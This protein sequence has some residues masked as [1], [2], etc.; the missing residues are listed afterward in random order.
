AAKICSVW[1]SQMTNT[2]VED[3]DKGDEEVTDAAKADAEKTSK[4]KD[5]AK[6][7][8]LPPTSSSL[9]VS[10][11]FGDQFLKLSSDSSLVSTVKDT[12]DAEINSLLEVKIQ[13]EVPHI[14]SPSILIVLV[15]V[16][17]K[18]LVLS[19]VQESPSKATVTTL[20][21]P[22]VSTTPLVPQQTTTSIPIPPIT[23][24]APTITTIQIPELP[25]KQSP[26]VDLEQESEKTPSDILKIKKEQAEKKKMLK[27]TIKS[28]DKA[29]LKE[30]DQKSAIYQTMHAD[31]SFNRNP[32]NHRL[33][34]A[35]ME[36]LIED[37]H[38]IDKGVAYTVQDHK[39]KHDDDEDDDDEDP[40]AGPNQCK[41]IKRRRIKESNSSKKPS[42]TKETPKGKAPSKGFKIGKSASAKEPVKEP[43][44]EVVMDDAGEDVVRNDDQPQD[45][46]EPK[47]TKTPNLD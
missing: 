33:Y 29:A 37:E 24:D 19:T 15:S 23:T 21:P 22:S 12:T 39:R 14:Q 17:Y 2:E 28:T 13:S 9:S 1:D 18:P 6:K 35:L 38:A 8:E 41:K 16:I 3:S 7:T 42:T 26:T 27:F 31:K 11:G 4:V 36:E 32:A 30:Y 45:A 10:L 34:H 40:P 46:S 43:T 20:P 47:T 25:K 44:A 5:D